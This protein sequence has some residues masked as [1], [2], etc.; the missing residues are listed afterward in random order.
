MGNELIYNKTLV[1][2]LY[3]ILESWITGFT[4]YVRNPELM[5]MDEEINWGMNNLSLQ[6]KIANFIAPNVRAVAAS[7]GIDEWGRT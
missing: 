1:I 3:K 6:A 4:V 7:P 5:V 2:F